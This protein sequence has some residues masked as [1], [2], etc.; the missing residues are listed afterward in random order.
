VV[1]EL[2]TSML[3]RHN[4]QNVLGPF[5]YWLVTP[6]SQTPTPQRVLDF[7]AWLMEHAAT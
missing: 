2:Q 5:G 4:K 1:R 7:K 3:M 6:P